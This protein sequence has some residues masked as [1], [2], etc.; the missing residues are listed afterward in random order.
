VFLT[1][2][3]RTCQRPQFLKENIHSVKSQTVQEL[4]Q[5]FIVDRQKKGIQQADKSFVE[6]RHRIDGEYVMILDDDCWLIDDRF[7]EKTLAYVHDNEY[8]VLLLFRSKRPAGPPSAE[9][10]FPTRAVWGKTPLHQTTNCLCYMV[11]APVWKDKIEHFGIKPWGGDWWFLESV[12]SAGHKPNWLDTGPMAESRQLGRGKL[13][14]QAA[15]GWF[16]KV[17]TQEG[18]ADLGKDDWRLQ[19]WKDCECGN[20]K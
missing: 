6:N 17:A 14:E 12:L 7:V 20:A 4:E 16:E 9:T 13:F 3:T 5:I 18:L 2:V 1:I 15:P 8:P 11:K 10:V 19:L